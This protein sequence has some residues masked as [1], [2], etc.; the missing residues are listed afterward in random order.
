MSD[1]PEEQ[2]NQEPIQP[3][4]TVDINAEESA[5][6]TADPAAHELEDIEA[7]IR[8]PEPE[9]D[10]EKGDPYGGH[11]HEALKVILEAALFASGA[12]LSVNHLRDL[13]EQFER[14][15]G[16]TVRAVM[17]ELIASYEGKGVQL[18]E[19]ASGYRFQTD[20]ETAQWVSRL[21]EEKPQRYSRA[22]METIALIAYR[23]P[24]TRGEIED[25]R[26]VAVSS[27][28]IRTLLEREWVRVVGHRDV[29]GRPAM[30]ATT[31]QFLDYF[32][33]KS[34][35][36]LPSLSEIRDLEDLN[37][38]MEMTESGSEDTSETDTQ[39]E[40]TFGALIEKI[41]DGQA[42]GK[43]G[44]EF[45]DEHL[46][47]ELAEMD[48]VNSRFES[49]MEQ[50]RA[51]HEHPDLEL[52]DSDDESNANESGTEPDGNRVEASL[53]DTDAFKVDQ[54]PETELEPEQTETEQPND[55]EPEVLSEEDQ[56]AMIQAKLAQQQ[57]L[58]DAREND[59]PREDKE[60]E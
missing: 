42:S 32:S 35:D 48:D 21:W 47:G 6:V 3:E 13:F 25:V 55:A 24:M 53:A 50:A 43:T 59:E 28:I 37:P 8:E 2:N 33:L 49:A 15:H 57:A 29:P 26:G 16:K 34:L 11:S 41:R 17:A 30:Y 14:P 51:E 4:E 31:R 58:L 18:V 39:S 60:D 20:P 36:Q 46:D 1:L 23:Q 22:L 56:W 54:E 45:I 12:I 38:Q 7:V 10:E 44:S 27:N 19:V 9:A 40:I 5:D 52:D